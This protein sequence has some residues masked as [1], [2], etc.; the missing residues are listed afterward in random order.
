MKPHLVPVPQIYFD[1]ALHEA[2][3]DIDCY[4]GDEIA[5]EFA[6]FEAVDPDGDVCVK[7]IRVD[8][9]VNLHEETWSVMSNA[10][11]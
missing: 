6:K 9:A 7:G 2:E 3:I 1:F 4:P 5:V 11:D 8:S 10:E